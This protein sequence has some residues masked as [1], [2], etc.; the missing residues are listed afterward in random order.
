MDSIDAIGK[1]VRGGK[2][3]PKGLEVTFGIKSELEPI[4]LNIDGAREGL[5]NGKIDRV[6]SYIDQETKTEYI[7]IVDYKLSSHDVDLE[8]VGRSTATAIYVYECHPLFKKVR[9]Y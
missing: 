9:V 6:D 7:S 5:V 3:R 4:R 1:Q 8:M 2:L